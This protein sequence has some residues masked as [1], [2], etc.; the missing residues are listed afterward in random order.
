MIANAVLNNS[1]ACIITLVGRNFAHSRREEP[2]V[3]M[4]DYPQGSLHRPFIA[5]YFNY[6]GLKRE[7]IM[8]AYEYEC[9]DC[10][11]EFVLY[12]S[13]KELEE[14]PKIKCPSCGCDNVRKKISGFFAKTSKKS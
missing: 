7:D 12:I 1:G 3:G 2:G 10:K 5:V 13:L 6:R 11:K 4:L 9:K 8:P 14:Q